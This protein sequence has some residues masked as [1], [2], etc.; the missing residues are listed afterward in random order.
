MRY[1]C[2]YSYLPLWSGNHILI[3]NVFRKITESNKC[4]TVYTKKTDTFVTT[5]T[6]IVSTSPSSSSTISKISF[7]TTTSDV[8]LKKK[9]KVD[10][11]MIKVCNYDYIPLW[12]GN[13]VLIGNVFRKITESRKCVDYKKTDTSITTVTPIGST[14]PSTILTSSFGTTTS[15]VQPTQ[16]PKMAP[17]KKKVCKTVFRA[18]PK[19]SLNN[20]MT[21]KQFFKP[22]TK[23]RWMESVAEKSTFSLVAPPTSSTSLTSQPPSTTTKPLEI[24]DVFLRV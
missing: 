21:F 23:C 20:M 22:I 11:H 17:N 4:A 3:G 19:M 7:E 15:E 8:L 12:S 1:L 5:E 16:S 9:P 2:N 13:H 14:S 6:P 24:Y 18:L 10:Q